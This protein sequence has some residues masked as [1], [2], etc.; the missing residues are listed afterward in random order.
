ME[1]VIMMLV[2]ILFMVTGISGSRKKNG[3]EG[4]TGQ[5]PSAAAPKSA[6]ARAVVAKQAAQAREKARHAAVAAEAKKSVIPDFDAIIREAQAMIEKDLKP[7]DAQTAKP[8]VK[9]V[10]KPAGQGASMLDEEGCVGGSMAHDHTEGERRSEHA[11]HV[12]AMKTRDEAEAKSAEAP[13]TLG[14]LDAAQMRRAIVMAE[15]LDKPKALRAR[16]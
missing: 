9:P 10:V 15:I 3:A 16:R 4:K 8:T 13:R 12:A 5:T 14:G 6:I 1:A 11:K 2:I 7:A